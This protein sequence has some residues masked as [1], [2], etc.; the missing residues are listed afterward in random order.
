M[1]TQFVAEHAQSLILQERG[2][3]KQENTTLTTYD[4]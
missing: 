4:L 1:S 3:E 2:W